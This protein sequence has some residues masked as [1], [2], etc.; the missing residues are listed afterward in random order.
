[1]SKNTLGISW[2]H[3]R[4]HAV[5]Q[6]SRGVVA[7][8]TSPGPVRDED[9]EAALAQAVH[10]TGFTGHR[11][12]VVLE[13]RNLLFHV[14]E[15]PPAAGK[16]LEQLLQRL[17]NQSRFFEERAAWSRVE[18]P[19]PRGKQR[20]LLALLPDSV[21]RRLALTCTA[22]RLQLVAAIP[23]AAL[24]AEHLRRL[25]LTKDEVVV[26]AADFGGWLELTLGRGDGHLLFSRSVLLSGPQQHERSAQE[27]NRTLHYAQQQFGVMVNQLFV[28]GQATFGAL[29]AVEIRH[30]LRIQLSPLGQDPFYFAQQAALSSPKN[31]L[32]LVSQA[33]NRRRHGRQLAAAAMVSLLAGTGLA[34]GLIEHTVRA[35]ETEAIRLEHELQEQAQ[36]QNEM[37]ARQQEARH[38]VGFVQFLSVTN[39]PPVADLFVRY[40]GAHTP[41]PLRVSD[42]KI[43]RASNGW[44]FTLQGFAQE[45]SEGM[46]SVLNNFEEDLARSVFQVR[47]RESTHRQFLRGGA[48]GLAAQSRAGARDNEKPFFIWGAIE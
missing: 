15:T 43:S 12:L 34:V 33:E 36:A 23:V 30:G 39:H 18:V 24:F 13:H 1:M 46:L 44:E 9:F 31:P 7:T 11:V 20:H 2:L 19:P 28:V 47:V 21:V 48:A 41:P 22:Q 6:K 35:R 10:Q 3:G 5:A 32:N 4:F 25:P 42:L 27:I 14:Q 16:V 37:I 38:L 26:L 45:S 29:Q 17:V 40:L 8:W